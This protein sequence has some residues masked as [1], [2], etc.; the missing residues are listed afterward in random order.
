MSEIYVTSGILRVISNF[1]AQGDWREWK[2]RKMLEEIEAYCGKP[3]EHEGK[4][5]CL[6]HQVCDVCF[7]SLQKIAQF[8]QSK[9]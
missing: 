9:L 1:K 4:C 3:E 8:R 5:H 6:S 7:S 2:I